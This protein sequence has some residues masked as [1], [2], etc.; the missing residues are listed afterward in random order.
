MSA[1]TV[2]AEATRD[3]FPMDLL[4]SQGAIILFAIAI[5]VRRALTPP[6]T[7]EWKLISWQE[8]HAAVRIVAR[9][10]SIYALGFLVGE[11]GLYMTGHLYLAILVSGLFV[12]GLLAIAVSRWALRRIERPA[13]SLGRRG[14]WLWVHD[15]WIPCGESALQRAVAPTAR[16][17]ATTK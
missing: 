17:N 13:V 5:A 16:A 2:V 12:E 3:E 15:A 9:R 10:R 6:T 7:G 11:L 4:V 1:L 8:A 14:G